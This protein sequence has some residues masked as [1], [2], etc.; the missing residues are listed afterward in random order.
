[1]QPQGRATVEMEIQF[2]EA[3][4]DL[5]TGGKMVMV[6]DGYN[7]PI[8]W[9]V[10]LASLRFRALASLT[11]VAAAFPAEFLVFVAAPYIQVCMTCTCPS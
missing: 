2:G 11:C 5:A 8:R 10:F 4:E 3:R 6:V 9:A 7:A 1:M